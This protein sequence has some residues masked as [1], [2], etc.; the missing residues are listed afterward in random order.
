MF[1]HDDQVYYRVRALEARLCAANSR[2]PRAAAAHRLMA[3]HYAE[4]VALL[5]AE[6]VRLRPV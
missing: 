1:S 5:D 6:I 3:R 4:R 2:H